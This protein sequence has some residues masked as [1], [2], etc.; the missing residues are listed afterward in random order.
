M[1]WNG[2][3]RSR[4]PT[5]SPWQCFPVKIVMTRGLRR[6]RPCRAESST[7]YCFF[8]A[9]AGERTC[10]HCCAGSLA[11]P[12]STWHPPDR[13]RC[14]AS[15][16]IC[17][18]VALWRS[19]GSSR[20]SRPAVRWPGGTPSR[21]GFSPGESTAARDKVANFDRTRPIRDL[22]QLE[23][24]VFKIG[25]P[26][27]FVQHDAAERGAG[28]IGL[29]KQRLGGALRRR[30]VQIGEPRGKR[31]KRA[32]HVGAVACSQRPASSLSKHGVARGSL[33]LRLASSTASAQRNAELHRSPASPR[34]CSG[35]ARG[36]T[37][38][39]QI[40]DAARMESDLL[41]SEAS[42]TSAYYADCLRQR[43]ELDRRL[44]ESV[45]QA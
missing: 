40:R 35:L 13:G 5:A 20:A 29:A 15:P 10:G 18:S 4:A 36:E 32:S 19:S 25:R 16:A 14:R 43:V 21:F 33:V 1:E 38:E 24:I 26:V 23:A 28:P 3:Q 17:L 9:R 34:G 7:R 31:G 11:M 41:L 12:G 44:A 42:R 6:L 22:G 2:C 37:M 45:R 39:A 27:L 30:L 8:F